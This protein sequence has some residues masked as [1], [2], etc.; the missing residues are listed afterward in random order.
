[1]LKEQPLLKFSNFSFQSLAICLSACSL[2]VFNSCFQNNGEE[3]NTKYTFT[4]LLSFLKGMEMMLAVLL[5]TL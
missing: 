1:M 5:T 4:N 2:Y 3:K